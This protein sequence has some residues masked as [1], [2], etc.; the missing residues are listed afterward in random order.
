MVSGNHGHKERLSKFTGKFSAALVWLYIYSKFNDI[1]SIVPKHID[2]RP[3]K[4]S[5]E[6]FDEF[7][8]TEN[9]EKTVVN[10]AIDILVDRGI[11]VVE[12]LKNAA[13][14]LLSPSGK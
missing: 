7:T 8:K 1:F 9:I 6:I 10:Q 14:S 4:S 5:Q 11:L 13:P 12:S 3:S 2:G